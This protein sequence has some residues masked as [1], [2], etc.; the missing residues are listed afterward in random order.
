MNTPQQFCISQKFFFDAAHTLRRDIETEGSLRVHGHTYYAEVSIA[1]TPDAQSG[2]VVDLG[3][4]RQRIELLRPLLDHRLL[5]DVPG[6]GPATLENLCAF[7]WRA[8]APDFA[9][10]ERVRVWREALGDSCTLGRP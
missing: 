10:L 6:L 5:D 4:V 8:L 1:G 7:I 9:G 2:M 3:R